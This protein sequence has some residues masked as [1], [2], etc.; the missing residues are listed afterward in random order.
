M[1]VCVC[2]VGLGFIE[3]KA[4]DERMEVSLMAI[5]AMGRYD[6]AYAVNIDW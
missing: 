1:C 3:V 4:T 5:D 6:K 2:W